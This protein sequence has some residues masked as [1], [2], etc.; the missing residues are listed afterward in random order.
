MAHKNVLKIDH[1]RKVFMEDALLEESMLTPPYI[2]SLVKDLG[3]KE[4]LI[5]H[6]ELI[7]YL[8]SHK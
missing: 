5:T 7:N 6:E 4:E 3:I 2:S 1:P 8:V